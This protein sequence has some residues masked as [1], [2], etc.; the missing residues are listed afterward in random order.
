MR[1]L[2][3]NTAT[4]ITV[5]PFFD[6]TDGITPEVALTATN[7]KL[8]FMVDDAGV[9]TL[10][11]DATA[12]ASGGA[13]DLVHVT[14][15]DAGFYDLELAAANVNY[16]GRASLAITYATDHCP[17]F[18]EFMILP[19][20]VYDSLTVATGAAHMFG[21]IDQGTAQS[22][23]GSTIVLR[24][25]AAFADDE[26]VGC[27]V[28]I[29][30]G[31]GVGQ[32]RVITDY[33]S[34]TDTATV[35]PDFTTT[36]SGT[37]EYKV[38]ASPAN[39]TATSALPGVD[40][41]AWLGTAAATPTVA[42]VPEVDVTHN[43]GT[44]ITAAAGIQEVKVASIA[45]SA[46]TATAIAADA[47]TAAKIATDA[48]GSDEL[49]TSAVSKILTTAM[50]EAYAADGATNTVAQALYFLIAALSE[51]SVSGTTVTLK[52]LDGSTTA[53]VLTL[54]N[55]SDPTSITRAS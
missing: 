20:H 37:I 2:R 18:H 8:T 4:R 31:T 15:D 22:A 13:N 29:T 28:L 45:A 54:S 46:I 42:G 3:S 25:A 12:T 53:A 9:P 21:I 17:V 16:V 51:F 36:P 55:A 44:A 19:A 23:T 1:F 52:K 27:V 34:A 14:N 49:A 10:V 43:A 7:E 32:V 6:K 50:T 39:P 33:V 5:G 40:V 48:I 47:I 35:S 30:G 11:L 38:L 26:L 41:K 24:A